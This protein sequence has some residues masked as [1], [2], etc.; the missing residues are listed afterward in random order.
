MLLNHWGI[1]EPRRHG[2]SYRQLSPREKRWVIRAYLKHIPIKEIEAKMGVAGN[3]IYKWLNRWGVSSPPGRKFFFKRRGLTEAQV[4][5]RY[6]KFGNARVTANF[7]GVSR[8]AVCAVLR[9]HNITPVKELRIK[10]V[11]EVKEIIQRLYFKR[12]LSLAEIAK[13]YGVGTSCLHNKFKEWGWRARAATFHNTSLE[14]NF[15]KLLA[16]MGLDFNVQYPLPSRG[17]KGKR[18][19][20]AYD[21][22][23]P[24]HNLLIETNGDYWHGNPGMY[25]VFDSTQEKSKRRDAHKK[26]LA[27]DHGFKILFV[28]EKDLNERP[29]WVKSQVQAAIAGPTP[30]PTADTLI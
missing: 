15:G 4:I 3:T 5:N 8:G 9:R 18:S 28:W 12:G 24:R 2:P 19:S 25:T 13:R 11:Y 20:K 16:D 29:E 23:V 10:K 7:Y 26:E 1:V 22:C 27:I 17:P 6:R 30:K 21:F 14:R